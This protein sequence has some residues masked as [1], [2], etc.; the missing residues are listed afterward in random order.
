MKSLAVFSVVLI[1]IVF[2][3]G[4]KAPTTT[5]QPSPR[6][7]RATAPSR[8]VPSSQPAT[9]PVG[10]LTPQEEIK[11]FNLAPGFRAEIVAAEP[12]VE[13]PVFATFDP[14]GR[15]WV[16]EMRNY[17][18]DVT[19]WGE[20]KPTGR[21]SIL[22]DTDGDGQMDRKTVFAD[23][24]VLPRA[25]GFVKDGV[26]II[27]PP[28]L[29]FCRDTNG[30]HVSDEQTVV[31]TDFGVIDNPE[32]FANGM[33][34]GLDNW[35]YNADDERRIRYLGDGKFQFD[36][37][38]V[39]GQW[40]ISKDDWGR[41]FFNTNS[42][43][44]RGSIVPP[45]Y[46]ARNPR[47]AVAL[48][49]T[50]IAKDQ[51]I[52]PA[53]ATTVNR[54]YREGF[55]RP[56]GRLKEFTAACSPL[57]YRGNLF[58]PEYYGNAFVCEPSANLVRRA[59]ISESAD[60]KLSAKNADGDREFITSTYER[61]RPVALANAPDGAIYLVDMHHGLIQHRLSLTDYGKKQYLAKKLNKHLLTG[62]I[63]RIVPDNAPTP[64]V[65]PRLSSAS[66]TD[67]V[68]QLTHPNGW[69]RDTAQRLLVERNDPAAVKPLSEMALH[70][71]LPVHR[72]NALWTLDGMNRL[73]AKVVHATMRDENPKLR[74]AAIRLAEPKLP[75]TLADV[76]QLSDDAD[77][78]VRMQFALTLSGIK[79]PKAEGALLDFLR[80]NAGNNDLLQASISGLATRE[81]PMLKR[82]LADPAWNE[83]AAGRAE[84]ITALAR[85]IT[86][87]DVTAEMIQL[88]DL[89]GE[90]WQ[91]LAMLNAIPST[92]SDA[93]GAFKPIDVPA[94]PPAIARLRESRNPKLTAAAEK[95]AALFQWPGKPTSPRPKVEPLNEKQLALFEIGKTTYANVCAQCHKPDGFGQQGKAPPLRN[96]PWAL[97]PQTRAIRIVL[98]GVRGPITVGDGTFTG[99]MP[100]LAALSDEQVAGV[101][102]FVRRSWGHEAPPVDPAAVQSIRDWTQA[103]RD[104][105]TEPELLQIK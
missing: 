30:D 16:A 38:P 54:G 12:M 78:Q 19:G 50:Q 102:T 33:L 35:I 48:A 13:H 44:L 88:I 99:D 46:S 62:R 23:K 41:L 84:V 9:Q 83:S 86:R 2:L 89:T 42:D 52:Y 20:N 103:R 71:A 14:D 97:G 22:E 26:L 34:W 39:L 90:P 74:A 4:A 64:K 81:I 57:I 96:S 101:L 11:T 91:Q 65:Q 100:S 66:T 58:G 53:H 15:M 3:A 85:S 37:I 61:F 43:Y 93:F 28:Q 87:R 76:L 56:D 24:L 36:P 70:A 55:L 17:M 67:L 105:W 59:V 49:D 40:G 77:Q 32:N 29:L 95:V 18:P 98:H 75:A 47:S 45:H 79:E 68:T 31:A 94:P 8:A 7:D 69:W 80:K 10:L 104:G 21:V 1:T 60:G 27:S 25:I 82:L 5:S 6:R 63:F 92:R 51:T 72:L 73:D